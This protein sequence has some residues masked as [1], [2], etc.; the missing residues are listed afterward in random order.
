MT[1][2]YLCW[3]DLPRGARELLGGEAALERGAREEPEWRADCGWGLPGTEHTG[4]HFKSSVARSL[5]LVERYAV[6]RD[7]S[8]RIAA[9]DGDATGLPRASRAVRAS[10]YV[11]R[12]RRAFPDLGTDTCRQYLLYYELARTPGRELSVREY[13]NFVRVLTDIRRVLCPGE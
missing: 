7:E 6:S 9:E 1:A 2:E 11:A 5:W 12:L 3:G 13:D 8:L 10:D 4:V